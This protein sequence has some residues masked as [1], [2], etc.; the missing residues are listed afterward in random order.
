MRTCFSFRSFRTCSGA[1]S[2]KPRTKSH[3]R[4]ILCP[5]L[6]LY[7]Y[8]YLIQ[9]CTYTP[10][11]LYP[12]YCLFTSLISKMPKVL[13]SNIIILVMITICIN[14]IF[15]ISCNRDA[16]GVFFHPKAASIEIYTNS[17]WS[18]PLNKLINIY[19]FVSPNNLIWFFFS[20]SLHT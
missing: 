16:C 18:F 10:S 11:N 19:S 7:F 8:I 3:Q 5:F 4:V 12:F 15:H 2:L 9:G 17:I 1:T 14:L 6:L 20:L 13:Y